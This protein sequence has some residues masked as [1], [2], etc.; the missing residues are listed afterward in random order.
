M[1]FPSDR[2]FFS[3]NP[4]SGLTSSPPTDGLAVASIARMRLLSLVTRPSS[5]TNAFTLVELLVVI[6]II[7][8]L[9]G[10][11][12]PAFRGAQTQAR[13]TQAKNDV[14]QIVT[15]VTAFYTEYGTYPSTFSP[16]MTFDAKN[17][18][19]ND[20][21]FNELRGNSSAKLN[22]KN[23]S[24]ITLPAVK[25]DKNPRG[26]FDSSGKLYDPW[27]NQYIVRLDTDY[28]NKVT[29]PY[30][31]NAGPNPI[32]LGVLAWSM[33]S[34]GQTQSGADKKSGPNDD[35]VISWQ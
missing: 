20:K 34:D 25:D 21:L 22:L 11:L 2:H 32:D 23:I 4:Q 28:D 16:E 30:S 13:K 18:S 6:V 27:G 10:L 8:I 1:G 31:Q 14:A 7:V 29:N 9:M 26:G 35:D 17:G 15:A 5:L 33:G 3:R 19:D 24:F 12:F